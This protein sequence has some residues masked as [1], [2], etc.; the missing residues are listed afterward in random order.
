MA[1]KKLANF[2]IV[3]DILIGTYL[4]EE[5]NF[6]VAEKVTVERHNFTKGK[7]YP[8]LVDYRRVTKT[9]KEA[10]DY[11]CTEYAYKN[12]VAM[13][14]LIDSPVGKIISAFF[15]Q[16]KKP[17]YILKIFNNKAKALKWLKQFC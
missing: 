6:E 5:V 17:P 3:D 2:E 10:R 14:V 7:N 15:F 8:V 4:A 11:F 1:E 12:L 9:T 13:A 16:I